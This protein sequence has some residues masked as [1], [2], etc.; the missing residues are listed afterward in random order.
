MPNL[1]IFITGSTGF[2]GG[3]LIKRILS[4]NTNTEIWLL[5]RDSKKLSATERFKLLLK[6]I[7]KESDLEMA[8]IDNRIHLVVGELTQLRFGLD[9]PAFH[10]LATQTNQI[11]HCAASI[12]LIGDLTR[13]RKINYFGT[14]QVLKLAHIANKKG[15]FERLNYVST[16]YVAGKRFGTIYE[17]ELAHNKGFCNTYEMVKHETEQMVEEAKTELPITIFRPS[18]IVGDSKTGRTSSFNV[19]YEP[20][21]L[22]YLGKLKILPG[23]SKS[24]LD[25]VPID[26]VCD[27]LL[28]LSAMDVKVIGK[29]FHLAAGKNNGM[30][31]KEITPFCHNYVKKITKGRYNYPMPKTIHPLILMNLSRFMILFTNGKKR[32]FYEKVLTY[33]NYGYYYKDFDIKE[34]ENLLSPLGIKPPKLSEYLDVLCDYAIESEF[35]TK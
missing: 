25:V 9:K 31:S 12:H 13:M 1:K 27:A 15:N 11:Y 33:S 29:T 23:S 7:E 28:A 5:I 24:S 35:G 10:D 14:Q 34:T 22:S 19:I 2:L 20:M 18:I 8:S 4:K 30:T 17:N 6:N 26:Y 3:E 16:A 21:R 32:R